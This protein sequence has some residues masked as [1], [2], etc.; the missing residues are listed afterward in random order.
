MKLAVLGTG[1]IVSE[2][3]PLLARL[4]LEKVALLSTLRSLH[5]AGQMAVRYGLSGVFTDY[6]ALLDGDVDTVYIALPNHLHYDYARRALERGKHVILEKPAV[7]SL[8]EFVALTTLAQ[9]RG[10]L[11]LEAVSTLHLPAFQQMRRDVRALG[12][13]EMAQLNYCQYSS[14][15]EAFCRGEIHPVFDPRCAGG[16][17]YDINIYN[18]HAAV[19]L[20]GRPVGVTYEARIERGIDLSGTLLLD[21]GSFRVS[22]VGAKDHQGENRSAIRGSRGEIEIPLPVNQMTEYRRRYGAQPWEDCRFETAHR[23]LP[24]L[25]ELCRIIEA[26][27][28]EA[29]HR[30][31]ELSRIVMDVLEQARIMAGIQFP[32]DGK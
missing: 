2:V 28:A 25:R 5:R 11:L 29:A 18:V 27:D 16:A 3:L 22:C 6:D 13:I 1:K 23:L 19:A 24:E 12:E 32:G 30:L 14:R 8:T 31:E 15:Y 7:T 21:Y 9:S 10:V 17:L 4:R 26:R 20:F